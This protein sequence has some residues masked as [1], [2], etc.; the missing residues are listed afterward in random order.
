MTEPGEKLL[1]QILCIITALTGIITLPG[2]M[3]WKWGDPKRDRT[4]KELF[5]KLFK[6]RTT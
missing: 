2:Y 3:L 6:S 5:D 1:I 4:L